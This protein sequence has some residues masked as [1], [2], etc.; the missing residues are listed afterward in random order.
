MEIST[1]SNQNQNTYNAQKSQSS[2]DNFELE[3]QKVA[4]KKLWITD[5]DGSQTAFYKADE[6]GGYIIKRTEKNGKESQKLIN[7]NDVNPT[8]ASSDEMYVYALNLKDSG[9]AGFE[10]SVMKVAMANAKSRV[11]NEH[12]ETFTRDTRLDWKALISDLISQS[13][14]NWDYENKAKWQTFLEL[15]G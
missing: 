4:D 15:L 10:E 6:K 9:R 7:A 2:N 12:R 14:S 3:L 13:S 8:N 1:I 11:E 5:T